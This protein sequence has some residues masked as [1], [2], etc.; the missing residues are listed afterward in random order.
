[1]R[2]DIKTNGLELTDGLR[3]HTERRLAFALDRSQHTIDGVVVRLS[4]INGPRG[5]FDKRCQIRIPLSGHRSV[6]I[7]ETNTDL[8]LAIDRATHRVGNTLG[9]HLA[10]RRHLTTART[11]PPHKHLSATVD[12]NLPTQ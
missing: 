11:P 4:D 3:D 9:R 1:M 7:E 6:V 10:R 5:G 2:I 12:D 8:Y